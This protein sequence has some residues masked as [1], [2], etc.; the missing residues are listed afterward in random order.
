MRRYNRLRN[1]RRGS[2]CRGEGGEAFTEVGED[3][4]EGER[5]DSSF[6]VLYLFDGTYIMESLRSVPSRHTVRT[7]A[8]VT[9]YG[10]Q[11]EDGRRSSK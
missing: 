7:I 6:F 11:F 2:S 8:A 10:S 5:E 9:L 3:L 1:R 4:L